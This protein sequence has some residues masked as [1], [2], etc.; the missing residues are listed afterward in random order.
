M[1]TTV[2]GVLCT[3]HKYVQTRSTSRERGQKICICP[4]TATFS[5]RSWGVF[6]IAGSTG[7]SQFEQIN[8][9]ASHA[10]T[11]AGAQNHGCGGRRT[12]YV[13]RTPNI[14]LRAAGITVWALSP[15]Y[16]RI[17]IQNGYRS[18]YGGCT[19]RHHRESTHPATMW[20]CRA[21]LTISS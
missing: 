7:V 9:R 6:C 5:P 15:L 4:S 16:L 11:T 14:I 2:T 20:L 21:W 12:Q 18:F 8:L 1:Q 19:T 13:S 17:E 10:P 3:N